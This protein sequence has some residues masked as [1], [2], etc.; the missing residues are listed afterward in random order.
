[1]GEG[2]TPLLTEW[3]VCPGCGTDGDVSLMAD[4]EHVRVSCSFCETS[5][6][7]HADAVVGMD[8]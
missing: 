6:K 8:A 4:H 2:T 7:V 3:L 5:V 1:M